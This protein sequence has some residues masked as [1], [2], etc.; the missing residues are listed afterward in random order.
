MITRPPPEAAALMEEHGVS[1]PSRL[2]S[3][4]SNAISVS[5]RGMW[6]LRVTPDGNESKSGRFEACQPDCDQ[7]GGN[8]DQGYAEGLSPVGHVRPVIQIVRTGDIRPLRVVQHESVLAGKSAR[9]R[10]AARPVPTSCG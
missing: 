4:R 1:I 10:G 7:D 3:R 2:T 8:A 5:A 6:A 9:R